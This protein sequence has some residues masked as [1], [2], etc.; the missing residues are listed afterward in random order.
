MPLAGQEFERRAAMKKE[1]TVYTKC[2][3]DIRDLDRE[4]E[5]RDLGTECTAKWIR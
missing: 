5:D 4:V 2:D 3:K 1:N